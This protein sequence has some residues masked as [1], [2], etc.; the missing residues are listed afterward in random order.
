MILTNTTLVT[1]LRKILKTD[2]KI[3]DVFVFGSAAREKQKP[4]DI[5][6]LVVFK[7]KVYV[8]SA[9]VIRKEIEK[10]Q[11]P[12]QVVSKT[13]KNLTDSSFSARESILFEAR[14]LITGKNLAEEYG[15]SSLGLFKYSFGDWTK[16]QKTKFYHALNGRT[17]KQGVQQ[18]LNCIKLSDNLILVPLKH[19]DEFKEFLDS[20]NLKYIYSPMLLPKRMNNKTILEEN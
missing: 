12:I 9:Y 6:I 18:I 4:K 19:I 16:L 2:N 11:K 10:H 3:D 1:S 5:D 20:W 17:G 14:S 15:F 13:I 8:E 7:T